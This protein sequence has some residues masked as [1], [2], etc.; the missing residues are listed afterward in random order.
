MVELT[1]AGIA[2]NVLTEGVKFL[3]GQASEMLSAWRRR[4]A[5]RGDSGGEVPAHQ[6]SL[7]DSN[8]APPKSVFAGNL[9]LSPP[10]TE[11]LEQH[12]E[13]LDEI[14]VLPA[15]VRIAHGRDADP[16]DPAQVE[17][18]EALRALL[19]NIYRTRITL[20]GETGRE[21]SGAPLVR[22][23]AEAEVVA[24]LLAGVVATTIRIRSGT[25]EGQ[26]KA[27]EVKA[28]GTVAGVKADEIS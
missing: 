28:G 26:A 8:T 17:A 27:T 9:R 1:L 3:Y 20:V 12:E 18:A 24:G 11:V 6:V 4:R 14:L 19:E 21:P 13:A 10:N 2:A 22:G 5:A 15:L 7:G 25:V 16:A 23:E